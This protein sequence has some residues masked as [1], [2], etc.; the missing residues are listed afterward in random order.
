MTRVHLPNNNYDDFKK[1][2]GM[3]TKEWGPH[4]WVFL[5]T[6]VHGAYP[7]KL[8]S[9]NKEHLK[10]KKHFKQLFYSLQYTMPCIYCRNSYKNFYKEL[11]IEPYMKSRI[12]LMYWLY[13]MKDK[14]NKK[15]IAQEKEFYTHEKKRLKKQ[16]YDNKISKEEYYNLVNKCKNNNFKTSPSPPFIEVLENF[17]KM[18]ANCSKKLKTCS[19]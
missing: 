19:K 9:S 2:S 4:A 13:L 18:R 8:N 7:I 3:A 12:H 10:I 5:F 1:T 6:S 11:P 14:V 16:Y 15:L 17:E